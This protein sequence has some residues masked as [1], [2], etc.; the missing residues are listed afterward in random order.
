MSADHDIPRPVETLL[1]TPELAEA[2]ESEQ[3]RRFLDHIPVAVVVAKV[4]GEE[5]IIYANPE[6]ERLSGQDCATVEDQ[7]WGVLAGEREG[8]PAGLPLG[9]AVLAGSEHLGT[10]R[11]ARDA[12]E[13]AIVDAYANLIEDD[14]GV[15]VFRLV[16]LVDVGRIIEAQRETL[17][18]ELHERDVLLQEMQHRVKNNLQMVTALIR[19][20]ARNAAGGG[21]M[22]GAFD[23]LAGRIEALQLLY[24]ALANDGREGEVDLGTYLSQ[25]ASAVM[26]AHAEEGVRLELKVDAWP[27]SVNVAM[28]AGLVVNELLTNALKHAF[29]GRDGGTITLHSL[30]D[31]TGC[32]VV[33]ADDGNGLPEGVEWP[34]SGRLGALIVQSLR[35]NAR[36]QLDVESTPGE[37]TRVTIRFSRA[38][39][40]PQTV[41]A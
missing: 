35:Q 31:A 20:E 26:R 28:P 23:R 16:A 33:V 37:G 2:L 9:A 17:M 27:V 41:A 32:T 34:R 30:V 36:A 6:F 8:D 40:A 11:I 10:F 19:I 4:A 13:P 7:P 5:R 3:F 1:A 18:Q 22:D 14:A 38:A 39:A 29:A 21:N 15:P 12:A 25:V 24:Q